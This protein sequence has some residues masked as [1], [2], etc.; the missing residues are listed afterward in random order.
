MI[1]KAIINSKGQALLTVIVAMTIALSIGIGVAVRTLS[2]TRRT[3]DT[4]TYSRVVA[5]AEGGAESFLLKSLPEL[6][7][8]SGTCN[9]VATQSTTVP[10][11]CIINFNPPSGSNDV[12]SS[13]AVVTVKPYGLNGEPVVLNIPMDNVAEVNLQGAPMT[14]LNISWSE[15]SLLSYLVYGDNVIGSGA[16]TQVSCNPDNIDIEGTGIICAPGGSRTINISGSGLMGLRIKSY[17]GDSVVTVS[18]VGAET[19]NFPIQGYEIVSTGTLQES[20]NS[21]EVSRTVKVRMS[22]PYLPA[23]FDFALYSSVGFINTL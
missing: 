20:A 9:E 13:K 23:M 1:D 5:V 2:S 3:S 10:A 16:I 11:D 22:L 4:D 19:C 6:A 18:C 17:G 12:I 7:V 14:Q 8:L 15:N 21:S